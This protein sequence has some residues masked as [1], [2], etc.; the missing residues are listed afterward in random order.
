[1]ARIGTSI[2]T[3]PFSVR[4][5]WD[6]LAAFEVHNMEIRWVVVGLSTHGV[7]LERYFLRRWG[8][9]CRVRN[10]FLRD[11][12]ISRIKVVGLCVLCGEE[13]IDARCSNEACDN[14][15][16]VPLP[17]PVKEEAVV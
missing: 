5:R 17:V 6:V 9:V 12:N 15:R 14:T 11:P 4:G 13:I 8:M 3:F 1:M 2:L 16:R 10:D 7:V